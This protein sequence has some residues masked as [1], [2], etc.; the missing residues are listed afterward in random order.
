MILEIKVMQKIGALQGNAIK[1][2][3]SMVPL[4]VVNSI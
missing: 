1:A 2:E 4:T 3:E